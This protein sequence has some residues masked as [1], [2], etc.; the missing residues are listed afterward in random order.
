MASL[1]PCLKDFWKTT[2]VNGQDVRFRVLYGG[3]MSSKSHDAAGI[4]IARA[5]FRRENVLCMRM[6]QNKISDSVYTLLVQKIHAFKLNN[7]FEIQ[8]N[9]IRHKITG[10]VFNF[11][12]IARNIEEIKSYEGATIGWIEEAQSLTKEMFNTIRPTIMR[13]EGAEMWFVFNPQ[14]DYDYIY[15]TFIINQPKG[16]LVRK[17]N[18]DEN[19]FL[20]NNALS[21]IQSA[22]EEDYDLANHVYNGVPLQDDAKT[23]I[24]RSWLE[25]CVD[26]HL[27]ITALDEEWDGIKVIGFDVADD[28]D[29]LC[30]NAGMDGSILNLIDEWAA[31]EDE[32]LRST[33]RTLHN[34]HKIGASK[35][36][37]DS[38]G[39]GAGTGSQLNNMNFTEHFKFNSGSKVVDP[40]R[41]YGTT[42]IKNKDFFANYKAQ[43]WWALADRCRN[44]YNA[45]TKG[46]SFHAKDMFSINSSS[47]DQKLLNKLIL[48]LSR[49]QRDFDQRGK[50]CVEKKKDLL[51]RGVKS[52]NIADSIVIATSFV[53][54]YKP[55]FRDIM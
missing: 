34:A 4:A 18:Y 38:I 37:Y 41:K 36:G 5:N 32:L 31:S 3:R 12:G 35:I 17:I 44:T 40:N 13:N 19:P 9:C 20:G 51:K 27:K 11:Y 26:A 28:G 46:M 47:I 7:V 22:F 48:E 8:K 52:P 14:Y 43:S 23:I 2:K 39:V 16:T 24:K 21:D 30:A 33:Q 10:S 54:L 15:D 45:V 50:I 42:N 1:N 6:F 29:D 55:T 53:S 49:P 25:A